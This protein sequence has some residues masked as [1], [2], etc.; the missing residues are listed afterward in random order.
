LT[1]K[2][3]TLGLTARQ[4]KGIDGPLLEAL[5]NAFSSDKASAAAHGATAGPWQVTLQGVAHNNVVEYSPEEGCEGF[6]EFLEEFDEPSEYHDDD[7]DDDDGEGNAYP[8]SDAR[9]VSGLV[10]ELNLGELARLRHLET[11][12]TSDATS[13][14]EDEFVTPERKA[15]LNR[16][17]ADIEPARQAAKKRTLERGTIPF[18]RAEGYHKSVILQS[19]E[20]DSTGNDIVPGSIENT[21]YFH[22]SIIIAPAN[23]SSKA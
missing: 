14:E 17:M 12:R 7:A 15:E 10:Y 3:T 1:H 21:M 11:G 16:R 22:A 18:V 8:R 20:A 13:D 6:E 2:Y 5:E 19:K 23:K 4:L 9:K